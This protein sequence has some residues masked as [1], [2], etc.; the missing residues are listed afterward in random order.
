MKKMKILLKLIRLAG[1]IIISVA[2]AMGLAFLVTVFSEKIILRLPED[3]YFYQ[4]HPVAEKAMI[5]LIV[6]PVVTFFGVLLGRRRG[7]T[8]EAL[9]DMYD[10]YC[11]FRW[12]TDIR[13]I[14]IVV[15]IVSLYCCFASATVV[16]KD[17]I[18][19]HS[20]LH[21]S[22]IAYE[23]K[24]V[25]RIQT[26]FGQKRFALLEY[27]K[28]GNFYYEIELDGK[29]KVFT[30]PSVNDR[31][32]RYAE[33]TYLE[34]EDFDQRLVSLGIPKQGDEKGLEACDLDQEYVDR[35]RRITALW[36]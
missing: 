22:G 28:K 25:S 13:F 24:D 9:E 34:L 5:Y 29:K 23:Y 27:Q 17:K 2:A 36:Q 14:L 11:I 32:E 6:V 16:T 3:Y 18:I 26:G 7:R 15:W 10:L 31:I 35:F 19:C 21:P 20:P 30:V 12:L 1:L 4:H 8:D 33:E